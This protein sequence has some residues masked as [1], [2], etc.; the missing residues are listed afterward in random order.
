MILLYSSDTIYLIIEGTVGVDPVGDVL[1]GF[2][3]PA[4]FPRDARMV[5]IDLGPVPGASSVFLCL[6]SGGRNPLG[7]AHYHPVNLARRQ[8]S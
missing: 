8:E 1:S 7:S 6:R 3:G 4:N 2:L 5:L